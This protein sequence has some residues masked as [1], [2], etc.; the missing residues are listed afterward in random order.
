M[1]D[2]RPSDVSTQ[3][4]FVQRFGILQ[5]GMECFWECLNLH[6]SSCFLVLLTLRSTPIPLHVACLLQVADSFLDGVHAPEHARLPLCT[7]PSTLDRKRS[8]LQFCVH[9]CKASWGAKK[10]RV[11]IY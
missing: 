8:G 5:Y 6:L 3:Q 1:P 2:L 9:L 11:F 7:P 4:P 10:D